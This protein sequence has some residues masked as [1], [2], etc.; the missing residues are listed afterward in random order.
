M[1][2]NAKR[3]N[4]K[5]KVRLGRLKRYAEY[6]IV[7]FISNSN[8]HVYMCAHDFDVISSEYR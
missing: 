3:I 2:I 5:E 8:T 1:S 6:V 4:R 7:Q